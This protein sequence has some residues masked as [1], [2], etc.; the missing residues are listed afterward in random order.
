[1][2]VPSYFVLPLCFYLEEKKSDFTKVSRRCM[3]LDECCSIALDFL[4]I[5]LHDKYFYHFSVVKMQQ[6][7]KEK[8][9]SYF[10]KDEC[11]KVTKSQNKF[12]KT[13]IFQNRNENIARISALVYKNF[14]GRNPSNIFVAILENGICSEIK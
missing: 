12:V 3:S 4:P 8:C 5:G 11:I 2:L 14:Q 1:M 13:L 6:I 7:C 9:N 10:F